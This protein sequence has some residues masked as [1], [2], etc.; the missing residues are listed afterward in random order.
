MQI[1]QC[2]VQGDNHRAHLWSQECS[3]H[4]KRARG[5]RWNYQCSRHDPPG[6]T[7]TG[8]WR[9]ARDGTA[10]RSY[11]WPGGHRYHG[12]RRSR[13]RHCSPGGRRAWECDSRWPDLRRRRR[14]PGHDP[15][16]GRWWAD[17]RPRP[18]EYLLSQRLR[19]LA[20]DDTGLNPHRVRRAV[21]NRHR[22][23]TPGQL[24]A[25]K[26]NRRTFRGSHRSARHRF[27]SRGFRYPNSLH[28]GH[29]F[30]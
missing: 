13:A 11:R 14:L 3:V 28:H 18:V 1:S 27:T 12:S 23:R 9:C 19:G 8:N 21:E 16:R 24:W 25:R 29:V 5:C 6:P 17:H 10:R 15:G 30:E 22:C 4:S 20:F 7:P 26:S 2:I